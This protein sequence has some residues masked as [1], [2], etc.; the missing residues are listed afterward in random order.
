MDNQV[1]RFRGQENM[2]VGLGILGEAGVGFQP[3]GG[4]QVRVADVAALDDEQRASLVL[5]VRD[6]ISYVDDEGNEVQQVAPDGVMVATLA[7]DGSDGGHPPVPSPDGELPPKSGAGA[8][9]DAW[10]AAAAER[11]ITITDDMSRD[12]IIRAVEATQA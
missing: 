9:R 2:L 1:L 10:A 4:N 6:P 11:K 5:L 8:T 3:I 12:D 7:S